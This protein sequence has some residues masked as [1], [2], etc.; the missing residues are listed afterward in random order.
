MSLSHSIYFSRYKYIGQLPTSG[1]L[2]YNQ[3][4][5]I[6][7]IHFERSTIVLV[8]NQTKKKRESFLGRYFIDKIF[9][10]MSFFE[11]KHHDR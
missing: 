2:R 10:H 4:D 5:K 7:I 11:R 1:T 6:P 9:L 3:A 8:V